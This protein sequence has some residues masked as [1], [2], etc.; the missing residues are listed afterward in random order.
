MTKI[1]VLRFSAMGD[2]MLLVP[3]IRSL[4]AAHH[5]VEVTVVTRPRFAAFFTGIER[6]KL[7]HADVDHQY[8][9]LFGL[10]RL[11]RV[12]LATANYT[13]VIDMHD[14]VRTIMLRNLFK[15]A[16]KKVLVFKKG[17]KEKKARTRKEKK[18]I[19][20]LPHTVE[21]YK[22]VFT[23]AG[24]DFTLLPGPF[25]IPAT[26]SRTAVTDWLSRN[27][28]TKKEKWI[29]LAPFAIHKTKIWPIS[30][31][32]SLLDALKKKYGAKFF[33]FGGGEDEIDYFN[34]LHEL[35]PDSCIVV[36]GQLKMPEEIALIHQL[37]LMICVDSSNMHLASLCGVPLLSIW[38]GTHPDVGFAPFGKTEESIIQI[39]R[40]KLPCRPC[41]VFGKEV[42]HRGDFACLTQIT[43]ESVI[44][45]A[46]KL[47]L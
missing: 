34:D 10:R 20:P 31:Y 9:G 23:R 6:V 13:L 36:A 32:P 16:G 45:K 3:V 14:H 30:N 33:L 21:R 22:E 5:S 28:L 40:E 7:F 38:G 8:K 15:L 18:I 12:L 43:V 44:V 47:L 11:I 46:E 24:F 26:D 2:V 1:L 35:F 19:K 27:N 41:S 42:C 4:V 39:S 17:R 29:G 37:D 25:L